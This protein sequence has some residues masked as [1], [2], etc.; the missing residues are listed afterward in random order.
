MEQDFEG[1]HLTKIF[2]RLILKIVPWGQRNDPTR[3]Y[4]R[5]SSFSLGGDTGTRLR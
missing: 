2:T 4:S 3:P 1:F 5:Y